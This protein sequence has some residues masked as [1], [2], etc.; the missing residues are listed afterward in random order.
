[1]N[2]YILESC[3]N[4]EHCMLQ[5]YMQAWPYPVGCYGNRWAQPQL[6]LIGIAPTLHWASVWAKMQCFYYQETASSCAR[7]CQVTMEI[8]QS[9]SLWPALIYF[10]HVASSRNSE[11]LHVHG[12]WTRKSFFFS[13]NWFDLTLPLYCTFQER[14]GWVCNVVKHMSHLTVIFICWAND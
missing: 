14:K 5:L 13:I 7:V 8:I 9:T 1:M 6:I 4:S 12:I 11:T 3:A 2:A 10:S